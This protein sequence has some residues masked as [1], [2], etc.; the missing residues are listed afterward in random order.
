MA[1]YLPDA[2][3]DAGSSFVVSQ[4]F[5]GALLT[6][7]PPMHSPEL[8]NLVEKWLPDSSLALSDKYAAVTFTFLK[9]RDDSC[10]SGP[11]LRRFAVPI[12]E[13]AH[14]TA[15]SS[16]QKRKLHSSSQLLREESNIQAPSSAFQ[17]LESSTK[18]KT[19][20][21]YPPEP[22]RNMQSTEFSVLT[23]NTIGN[24]KNGP[25]GPKTKLQRDHAW[26]MR[27]I[28]S[29][30]DC[31][32]RKLRCQ[33]NHKRM[34]TPLVVPNAISTQPVHTSLLAS[35]SFMHLNDSD[36]L[37]TL[38]HVGNTAEQ[39]SQDWSFGESLA[40]EGSFLSSTNHSVGQR[41]GV[42]FPNLVQACVVIRRALKL[43][44]KR[45]IR[46]GKLP[47]ISSHNQSM[48]RRGN[49]T[50]LSH[51]PPILSPSSVQP[52][53]ISHFS[54]AHD[55]V[56]IDDYQDQ[57]PIGNPN[58][59]SSPHSVQYEQNLPIYGEDNIPS[60]VAFAPNNHHLNETDSFPYSST[61]FHMNFA[62]GDWLNLEEL[63]VPEPSS[64]QR[65][66]VPYSGYS[67]AIS[68]TIKPTPIEPQD[69]VRL[70][71]TVLSL[72]STGLRGYPQLLLLKKIMNSVARLEDWLTPSNTE[73]P[74]ELFDMVGGT[75]TGG[76]Q[77]CLVAFG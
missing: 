57:N 69:P 66:L 51:P 3:R 4:S 54:P 36:E 44:R 49:S 50:D 41:S 74:H 43:W 8:Q 59:Y 39:F 63:L 65:S 22:P 71:E 30:N 40:K 64:N 27:K 6:F 10:P 72:D 73:L 34:H 33:P 23:P 26:K 9:W 29:C 19:R 5:P 62:T 42:C 32:K 45:P 48:A 60:N 76:I 24:L 47:E 13:P 77:S 52:W 75:S 16:G 61:D 31:R 11:A 46:I 58:R 28:G 1:E 18:P 53:G 67:G 38:S 21:K 14:A 35:S 12:P 25:R 7:D 70:D 17:P 37:S 20:K 2:S 56:G 55:S 68:N 15:K